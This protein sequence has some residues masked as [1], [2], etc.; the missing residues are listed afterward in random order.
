[1]RAESELHNAI[2]KGPEMELLL[3]GEDHARNPFPFMVNYEQR[4]WGSHL[5]TARL[6]FKYKL[7]SQ[8]L[9]RKLQIGKLH[10][11]QCRELSPE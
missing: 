7:P 6:K 3:Q 10:V 1:M 2:A 9:T 11:S 5:E 8:E 4:S